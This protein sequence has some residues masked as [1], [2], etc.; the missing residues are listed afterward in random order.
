MSLLSSAPVETLLMGRLQLS[1]VPRLARRHP[2]VLIGGGLLVLLIVM[3]IA[4]P[5]YA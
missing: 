4:A 2:L 3:A 5:L 1:D